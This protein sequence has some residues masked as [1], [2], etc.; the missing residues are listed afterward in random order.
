MD[1]YSETRNDDIALT[2]CLWRNFYPEYITRQGYIR[3]IN[4]FD[5]PREDGIKRVR[6]KIQNDE[7]RLLPTLRKVALK[8]KLN[9][10]EW[11]RALEYPV[12]RPAREV[13]ANYPDTK[14]QD[15]LIAKKEGRKPTIII[16]LKQVTLF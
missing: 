12:P 7:F 10:E 2:I 3:L 15:Q 1:N 8:R 4:L 5:L 6:A 13:I 11:Q 16:K 9:I 14:M